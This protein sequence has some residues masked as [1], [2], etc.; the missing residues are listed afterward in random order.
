MMGYMLAM[1]PCFGCKRVISFNPDLV[2]SI[3]VNGEKEPVCG[4]C[5]AAANPRRIA[6]GLA[7]IE[8]LPGAYEAGEE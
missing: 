5:I 2:P 8:V 1:A 4:D 3:R 6:N 7:P